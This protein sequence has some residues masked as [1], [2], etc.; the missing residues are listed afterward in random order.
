MVP[1]IKKQVSMAVR[2]R[3][4]HVAQTDA[5]QQSTLARYLLPMLG[6]DVTDVTAGSAQH[7]QCSLT[8][9]ALGLP[10]VKS[11]L[12]L[13]FR[14]GNTAVAHRKELVT[15]HSMRQETVSSQCPCCGHGDETHQHACCTAL[16]PLCSHAGPA[17]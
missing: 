3:D 17:A 5:L 1:T 13:Q 2:Q 6:P 8:W 4:M 14:S 16:P 9:L 12:K 15:R 10:T 7:I 11:R